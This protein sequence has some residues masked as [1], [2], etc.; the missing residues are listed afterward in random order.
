M[1]FVQIDVHKEKKINKQTTKTS[2]R[3]NHV[4]GRWEYSAKEVIL[5]ILHIHFYLFSNFHGAN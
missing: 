2:L 4:L 5:R 3:K 1:L